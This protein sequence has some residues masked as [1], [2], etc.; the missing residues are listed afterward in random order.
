MKKR[1]LSKNRFLTYYQK[2]QN[3]NSMGKGIFMPKQNKM[4]RALKKTTT[5]IHAKT[6][7]TL[8]TGY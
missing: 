3:S 5:T 6:L 7:G 4:P 1:N 8:Q 2:Q